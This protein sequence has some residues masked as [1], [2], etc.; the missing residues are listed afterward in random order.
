[1]QGKIE[2]LRQAVKKLT[3]VQVLADAEEVHTLNF[4]KRLDSEEPRRV[5][6]LL[7]NQLDAALRAIQEKLQPLLAN[8]VEEPPLLEARGNLL[9][10]EDKSRQVNEEI[11][12]LQAQVKT[13]QAK[14]EQLTLDLQ[15]EQ[16]DRKR[17]STQLSTAQTQIRHLE[18][19]KE[20]LTQSKKASDE[21]SLQASKRVKEL[22][23][24]KKKPKCC[25]CNLP[26]TSTSQED[27]RMSAKIS[28]PELAGVIDEL[29]TD[30]C[31]QS[32]LRDPGIRTLLPFYRRLTG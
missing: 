10:I 13:H 28:R 3:E 7:S 5:Q 23:D 27:W 2:K 17:I 18:Q 21:A 32:L 6:S 29:C 16:G 4:L 14:I 25:R 31:Y 26:M 1:M 15:T 22:E 12:S 9:R 20:Q 19:E 30:S 24:E 8:L 11:A